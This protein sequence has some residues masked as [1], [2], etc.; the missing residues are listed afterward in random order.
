M[1]DGNQP[2]LSPDAPGASRA[3]PHVPGRVRLRSCSPRPDRPVGRVL[4]TD[5]E[6]VQAIAYLVGQLPLFGCAKRLAHIDQECDQ[7]FG[8]RF[9]AAQAAA[10]C[11]ASDSSGASSEGAASASSC[12]PGTS[13]PRA[14]RSR[15]WRVRS[16]AAGAGT[17][18]GE[19]RRGSADA[20]FVDGEGLAMYVA[21]LHVAGED[22]DA[23]A[24]AHLDRAGLDIQRAGGVLIDAQRDRIGWQHASQPLKALHPHE[25]GAC[26][27][28]PAFS[29]VPVR[30]DRQAQAIVTEQVKPIEPVERSADLVDLI[31]R[32]QMA[33]ESDGRGGGPHE[34]G[35]GP[36]ARDDG[37]VDCRSSP[38]GCGVARAARA[39]KDVVGVRQRSEGQGDRF[40]AR[41]TP[42][43][44]KPDP[45]GLPAGARRSRGSVCESFR[46]RAQSRRGC[47]GRRRGRERRGGPADAGAGASCRPTPRLNR[48]K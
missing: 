45:S 30:D 48:S 44:R 16:S 36:P 23:G 15:A 47:R 46:R 18:G 10:D 43:G 40:S 1:N 19:G 27:V 37:V 7:L 3:W 39:G 42:T 33:A 34:L 8:R 32:E 5:A 9:C 6:G 4:Q 31:H 25:A 20:E 13:S 29:I 38:L 21:Q 24:A 41:R 35:T 22:R 14:R 12:R 17:D 2:A 26:I 28:R 11:A